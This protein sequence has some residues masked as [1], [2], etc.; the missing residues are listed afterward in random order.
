MKKSI[1]F[2]TLTL[3][4]AGMIMLGGACAWEKVNSNQNQAVELEDTAITEPKLI[5]GDKDAGGCLIGAGYSWCEPKQ[6]CLRV[7]EESCYEA[8]QL[9]LSRILA[10]KVGKTAEDIKVTVVQDNNTHASGS[11]SFKP[12]G[13]GEGGVFLA[14]KVESKWQVVYSGN[15]SINCETIAQYDFPKEMLVGFCD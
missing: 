11:I 8:D 12:F 14:V 13:E 4:G 15:G 1:L 6:K 7:W 2:T 10:E 5:G 9:A 3:I